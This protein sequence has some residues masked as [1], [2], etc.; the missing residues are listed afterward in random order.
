[1]YSADETNFREYLAGVVAGHHAYH[2]G[3]M[4]ALR[5][6]LEKRVKDY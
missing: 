3:Q 2:I 1:M 4:V 6:L 5:I